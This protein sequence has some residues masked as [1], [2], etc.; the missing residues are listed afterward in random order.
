V[1]LG[2]EPAPRSA[3]RLVLVYP[4]FAAPAAC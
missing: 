4:L 2:P 3:Q 1:D